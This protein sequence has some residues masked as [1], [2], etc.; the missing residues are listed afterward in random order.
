[1]NFVCL[2]SSIDLRRRPALRLRYVCF[3]SAALILFL[4]SAHAE[5]PSPQINP[6]NVLLV[7]AAP[8]NAIGDGVTTNTTA[9]QNAINAAASG[10]L[11][12]GLRG[13]VVEIP[14]GV[15]LSGPLVLKSSV[16]LQIDA[17]AVLKMLPYGQYPVSPSPKDFLSA[18]GLNNIAITGDGVIEGQGAAWWTAYEASGIA[19]PKAMFAPSNCR[20]MLVENVMFQSPP[21]THISLRNLCRDVTIRGITINTT[22]DV[23][24]DNTDGIDVNA[25][26][27]V[28]QNCSISCGDDHIA[29]GGDSGGITITN[30]T[31]GNGHGISIG[32]HTDGGLQ[33]LVVEDSSLNIADSHS[34]SSGIRLKSGRDRGGFVRNLT[35]RNLTI[36]NVQNPIFIS[37]Y[38][39]D[40]TIP[41]NPT[42]D[43][44]A[45]I[46]ELT[47]IWRDI[48]ISNVSI[49][50]P[51]GRNAGRVYGLPEMPITNL[52]F[53]GVSIQASKSFELY[54][55]R[56]ARFENCAFDLPANVNTLNV[57][58]VDLLLTNR[59]LNSN[60]IEIGG[61]SSGNATN[62]FTFFKSRV[63]IADTNLFAGGAPL[64]LGESTLVVSNDFN[65]G[66]FS[67]MHF[68]LGTNQTQ[69]VVTG[70]LTISGTVNV[71]AGSGFG[72]GTYTLFNY[73]KDLDWKS[74]SLGNVPSGFEYRW[75]T[76]VVGEVRLIVAPS[77]SLTPTNL[78]AQATGSALL[79]SWPEDHI[80]W[81]MEIQTNALAAGLTANWVTVAESISTN[82]VSL[83]MNLENQSVFV[84]LV[85]P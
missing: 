59:V 36:R 51:S 60:L 77:P 13:G 79:L 9:I 61:W 84:R 45:A 63:A 48:T 7:T 44:G 73:A 14:A 29:M 25:T 15:F 30:C 54:H 78:N 26:N 57:Y 16:R 55:V 34:L 46:T 50:T 75:D 12:N 3:A 21:N 27:C 49:V 24:S 2:C 22:S 66:T 20:T 72:K 32:S 8:F 17:G 82:E 69:V 4:N 6:D 71:S 11:T 39:P 31:F 76:N 52:T 28:I 83:P 37:S 23:L 5:I 1:M 81:R 70:N 47:P 40:N 58:D 43:P 85:Y 64:T 19:R 35:Y 53:Q 80:G 38:Y 33:N 56:R 67:A 65:S 10:G 62:Q 41:A 74:P 18:S 68:A 42:T